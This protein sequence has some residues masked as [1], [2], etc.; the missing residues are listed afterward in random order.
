M[1]SA[2]GGFEASLDSGVLAVCRVGDRKAAAVLYQRR[3]PVAAHPVSVNL[4]QYTVGLVTIAPVALWLETGTV[5][6]TAELALSLGW[7]IVANS[8]VAVSLLIFMI[9]RSEAARVS[10]LFFLVPPIAALFGWLLLDEVLG[11]QACFGIALA[12]TGV[13]MATK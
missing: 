10:A 12:L 13:R 8:I 3:Y 7:L 9:K 1:V 6:W 11:L 4:V 2:D 5:D